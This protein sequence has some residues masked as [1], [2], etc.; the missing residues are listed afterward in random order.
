MEDPLLQISKHS[1]HKKEE[2][3][4]FESKQ[5]FLKIFTFKGIAKGNKES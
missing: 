1:R 4:V 5:V 3:I 2:G